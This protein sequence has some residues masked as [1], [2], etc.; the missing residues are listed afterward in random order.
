MPVMRDR[1][2]L[3]FGFTTATRKSSPTMLSSARVRDVPFLG[4]PSAGKRVRGR[5]SAKAA[6]LPEFDVTK[7]DLLLSGMT[8]QQAS[9]C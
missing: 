2:A 9:L 8:L 4:P 6:A 5:P 7:R 1:P 3:K